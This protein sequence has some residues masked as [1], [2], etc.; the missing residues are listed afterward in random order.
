[1]FTSKVKA[2]LC[3]VAALVLTAVL[4]WGFAEGAQVAMSRGDGS[5][6]TQVASAAASALVR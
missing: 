2:P 5:V 6:V 4:S 1:M 3:A